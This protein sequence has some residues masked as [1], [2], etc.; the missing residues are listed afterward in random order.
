MELWQELF[1]L[2]HLPAGQPCPDLAPIRAAFEAHL[3]QPAV[4]AELRAALARQRS[5]LEARPFA[6]RMQL[7]RKIQTET[8]RKALGAVASDLGAAPPPDEAQPVVVPLELVQEA[9]V[10]VFGSCGEAELVHALNKAVNTGKLANSRG[11][12]VLAPLF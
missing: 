1:S 3:S 7:N 8:L 5:A 11:G 6:T 2:I 12:F 4:R 9:L 10:E